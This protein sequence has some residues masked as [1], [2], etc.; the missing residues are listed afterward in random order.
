MTYYDTILLEND[1]SAYDEMTLEDSAFNAVMMLDESG[2]P[3]LEAVNALLE[4]EEAKAGIDNAQ[5]NQ[6]SQPD[7]NNN[8]NN[9]NTDNSDRYITE[10]E[11]MTEK[12]KKTKSVADSMKTVNRTL[13]VLSVLSVVTLNPAA[14]LAIPLAIITSGVRKS[15]GNDKN[16][17]SE[18]IIRWIDSKVREIDDNVANRKGDVEKQKSVKDQLLRTK[19]RLVAA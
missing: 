8:N 13:K 4:A 11:A 6:S 12:V 1:L 18:K 17:E 5:Q 7:N 10:L 16:I 2:F 9:N 15:T 14:L 3:M 19:Q